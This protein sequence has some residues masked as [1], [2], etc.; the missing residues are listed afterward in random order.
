MQK[1]TIHYDVSLS[2]SLSVCLSFSLQIIYYHYDYKYKREKNEEK[3]YNGSLAWHHYHDHRRHQ[4]SK[5]ICKQEKNRTTHISKRRKKQKLSPL[6]SLGRRTLLYR[7]KVGKLKLQKNKRRIHTH[8][9]V[10]TDTSWQYGMVAY[11]YMYVV[12]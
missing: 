12:D 9:V 7:N 8:A 2:L 5:I 11:C 10:Q 4:R 1:V 3:T 6:Y